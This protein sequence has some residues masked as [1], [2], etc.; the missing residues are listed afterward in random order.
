MS[1]A[2]IKS[3]GFAIL[4]V[5]NGRKALAKHFAARPPFGVCPKALRIPIVIHGYLDSVFSGDDGTSRE[6]AVHVEHLEL[7]KTSFSESPIITQ[8]ERGKSF[9]AILSD[10]AKDGA[11]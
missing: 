4:D 11:Q 6:F 5:T 9:D 2:K 10:A 7:P 8:M 3:S 1:R